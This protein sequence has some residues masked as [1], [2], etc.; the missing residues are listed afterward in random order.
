MPTLQDVARR[1]G[2]STATVSKVLSNTPYFTEQ[3]RLRVM[4]AVEELNYRPNLAARALSTGKTRIIALVLPHI[5]DAIFKDPHVMAILEGVEGETARADY[6]LLLSTPQLSE[7]GADESYKRLIRSG[8]IDGM[9]AIDNVPIASVAQESREQSI[10]TVVIGYHESEYRVI[11]DDRQG[12]RLIM[13]HVIG[14]GHKRIGIISVQANKNFAINQRLDGLRA[15]AEERGLDF[16]QMPVIASDFSTAGGGR[17]VA[18]LMQA[19]P[20][21]T[22]VICLNDRM[23]MG[24]IQQLHQMGYKVPDDVTVT[25]YDNLAATSIFTPPMTTVD[26]R[27]TLLGQTAVNMLME[28]LSDK[29]PIESQSPVVL[30]PELVVRASS[31][32]PRST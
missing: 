14:L 11:C 32:V 24:A 6:S 15:V 23:A 18:N 4:Q 1:A 3:T 22:A 13:D 5:Y 8:Y 31:T 19:H 9:I 21:V 20:D 26:Q 16:D 17:A 12:G 27:A 7:D 28:V 2:V 25:G 10:P 30:S 29:A